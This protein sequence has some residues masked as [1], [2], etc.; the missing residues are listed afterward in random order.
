MTTLTAQLDQLVDRFALD[1]IPAAWEVEKFRAPGIYIKLLRAESP[2]LSGDYQLT[3]QLIAAVPDRHTRRVLDDLNTLTG[4]LEQLP[5]LAIE[6]WT[7][8][9]TAL[10]LTNNQVLPAASTTLTL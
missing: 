7:F 8:E 3:V 6:Q 10:E 9:D 4:Q 2:F 5:W 1:D